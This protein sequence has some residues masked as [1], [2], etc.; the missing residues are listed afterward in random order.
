MFHISTEVFFPVPMIITY[1]YP[2]YI[3]FNSLFCVLNIF[4]AYVYLHLVYEF[5]QEVAYSALKTLII[6][7]SPVVLLRVLLWLLHL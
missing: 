6:A 7:Y 5:L 3:V 1:I 2:F 4:K